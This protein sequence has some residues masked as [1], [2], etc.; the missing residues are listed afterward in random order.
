[1]TVPK[2]DAELRQGRKN[3]RKDAASDYARPLS[4]QELVARITPQNRHKE[5]QWGP[6]RGKEIWIWESP[7][8][9]KRT[10]AV[11]ERKAGV[12]G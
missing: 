4:L 5:V 8:K 7:S 10:P 12:L 11:R 6:D 3:A 1:M 9:N 2:F